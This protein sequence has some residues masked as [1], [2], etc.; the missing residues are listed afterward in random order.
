VTGMTEESQRLALELIEDAK[1][2][3]GRDPSTLRWSDDYDRWVRLQSELE[4]MLFAELGAVA[5][6]KYR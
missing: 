2:L 4:N 1:D 3:L 6:G 5:S